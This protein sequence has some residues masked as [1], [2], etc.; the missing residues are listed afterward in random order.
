M[1]L[2]KPILSE[3]DG[4]AL[5]CDVDEICNWTSDNLMRFNASKCRQMFVTRKRSHKTTFVLS[6]GDQMLQV[7]ENY[8]YLGFYLSSDLSWS[9]HIHYICNKAKRIMGILY[10]RFS[11]NVDSYTM[12]RLYTSLVRSHLEYGVEV[13]NPYLQ[14][15]IAAVENVQ[16]FA[17]RVC[18]KAW[19]QEYHELLQ[20]ANLQSLQDRRSFLS[21][22]T[23][24]KIKNNIVYFPPNFLPPLLSSSRLRSHSSCNRF[25]IPFARTNHYKY[26]FFCSATLLWNNLPLEAINTTSLSCFKRLIFNLFL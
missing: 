8:K 5:Q 1:L 25:I 16:K 18:F 24:F 19:S 2:Y 7:V 26:S 12:I 21:L 6:L 14:K 9:Y 17:L 23:L 20:L 10:R 4:T 11:N 13:W 3:A 22:V 15:D